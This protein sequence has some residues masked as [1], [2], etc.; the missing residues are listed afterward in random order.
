MDTLFGYPIR[1]IPLTPTKPKQEG[2]YFVV[3]GR[4]AD[5]EVG[6]RYIHLDA[7][8]KP[9]WRYRGS[10][11]PVGPLKLYGPIEHPSNLPVP[12]V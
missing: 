4:G 8:Q 11:I 2:W 1:L 6:I 7:D 5:N 10:K 9:Y 12:T 3:D